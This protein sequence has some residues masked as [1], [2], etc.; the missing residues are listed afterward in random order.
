MPLATVLSSP[1]SQNHPRGHVSKARRPPR[2]VPAGLAKFFTRP[3]ALS[4]FGARDFTALLASR[5]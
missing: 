5:Q 3:P 1:A 4:K 2:S